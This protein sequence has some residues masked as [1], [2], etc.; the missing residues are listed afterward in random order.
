MSEPWIEKYRPTK[1]EDI[2]L[3]NENKTMIKN[4]I[5]M[6][7]YPNMIFYGS[8]GTGKTT[9][10][11][12]LIDKYQKKHKCKNNHIHLNASHERGV[13]TI[14]H[15]IY[16]FTNNKNFFNNKKKFVLLDE[17][18]SMTKQAQK[19]LY[20]IIKKSNENICFIL[21]CN[22]MNKLIS[23]IR[24]TLMILTFKNITNKCDNFLRKCIT[25]E[26]LQI[27]KKKID[28]LKD[29]YVHDLRSI[30]NSL[31]NYDGTL[32]CIEPKELKALCK[33]KNTLGKFTKLNEVYDIN[34]IFISL[35]QYIYDNYEVDGKI[36]YMM[37]YLLLVNPDIQFFIHDF[38]DYFKLINKLN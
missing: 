12:C 38:I 7:N 26:N 20:N 37:K 18:D 17:V 10:I 15:Q 29:Y 13:E 33:C 25:N 16:Q 31:Q 3:S 32:S 35:F 8:P 1:I 5:K 19:Q 11:L 9:T 30:I 23:S 24:D 28:I 22:Y 27:T 21:I 2:I 4:M 34:N 14:R 36:V 6:D